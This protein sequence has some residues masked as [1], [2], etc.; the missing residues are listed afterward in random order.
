MCPCKCRSSIVLLVISFCAGLAAGG[1]LSPTSATQ[2]AILAPG[3]S[4]QEEPPALATKIPP[5]QRK[6]QRA[7][8]VS[9]LL[10][11]QID[12]QPLMTS[13]ELKEALQIIYAEVLERKAEL[14]I[15]IDQG[16]FRSENAPMGDIYQTPVTVAPYPRTRSIADVLRH[17]CA[18]INNPSG[19]VLVLRPG[20]VEITTSDAARPERLLRQM[21][22][23]DVKNQPL[24]LAI[25]RLAENYGLTVAI[26]KQVSR[27]ADE[28]VTLKS[29]REVTLGWTLNMLAE[30]CGLKFVVMDEGM[31]LTTPENAR[32]LQ[33][34]DDEKRWEREEEERRWLINPFMT[35]LPHPLR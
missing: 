9:E 25:E 24:S 1:L 32:P 30:M 28:P 23:V 29:H 14:P 16:A 27:K 20:L 17:L 5:L 21:N 7:I 10:K 6:D 4:N 15:L 22:L 13:M 18:Q 34:L 8:A 19:A 12:V 33:K 11:W 2:D 31:Y 35:G 3:S 26:D